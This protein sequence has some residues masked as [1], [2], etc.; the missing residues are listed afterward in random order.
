MTKPLVA[1]LGWKPGMGAQLWRVPE[2]LRDELAVLQEAAFDPR[3]FR[4]A[5]A[6]T[7]EELALAA[8]EVAV[9]YS[10]GGHLWLSYPKKSG[11]IVSDITRDVG[12]EPVHALGLLGV[13]Q[14]ALDEDWS[15]LRFR[16]REEIGQITR[17]TPTGARRQGRQRIVDGASRPDDGAQP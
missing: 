16:F 4:I 17:R 12:W 14:V 15:A 1:K 7:V 5:F 13:M 2:S 10:A 6:R 11:R 3:T 9:S 8:S